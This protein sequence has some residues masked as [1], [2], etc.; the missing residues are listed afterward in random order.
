MKIY[1]MIKRSL[2]T[3][4]IIALAGFLVFS[5]S[6]YAQRPGAPRAKKAKA[7]HHQEHRKEHRQAHHKK[8]HVKRVAHHHYKHLPKRGVVVTSLPSGVVVVKHKGAKLHAHNGVFYKPKG[9]ASFVV[10]RAPLGLRVK[11]V[12]PGHKRIMVRKRQ[13]YYHY[14]TFYAK[15]PNSDEYEV[16]T[17]PVGAEV[18]A[19][20]EGYDMEEIDGVVYYTMDDVKYQE[21]ESGNGDPVYEVVK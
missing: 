3:P 1:K 2:S 21:K 14:G 4:I 7:K 11:V 12:P 5:F 6:S 18:D 10:V 15:A 20:P 16:V 8:A 17:A 9:A 19:I 13:Y